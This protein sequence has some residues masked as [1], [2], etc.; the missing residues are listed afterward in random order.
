M[1]VAKISGGQLAYMTAI[2]GIGVILNQPTVGWSEDFA[3]QVD[4]GGDVY[5]AGGY[6]S[7]TLPTTF[8]AFEA[9]SPTGGAYLLKLDPSGTKLLFSTFIGS[10]GNQTLVNAME[11]DA[12]GNIYVAGTTSESTFPTTPGALQPGS[13]IGQ[14]L[15][16]GFISKFSPG[17]KLL[18]STLYGGGSKLDQ[19]NIASIAVDGSGVVHIAGQLQ[20][21]TPNQGFVARL[22]SSLTTLLFSKAL[23]DVPNSIQADSKGASYVAGMEMVTKIDASGAVAYQT[24]LPSGGFASLLL[25]DGSLAVAG[26]ATVRA[27]FPLKDTLEPCP[28][29]RGQSS[30]SPSF[31]PSAVFAMLDSTGQITL[32]TYLGGTGSEITSMVAGPGGSLYLAGWENGIDFPGGP[33]LAGGELQG[34]AFAFELNMSAIPRGMPSPGCVVTISGEQFAPIAP[35]MIATIFGNNLG[36]AT[37]AY[38]QL[39]STGAVPAQLAGISVTVGGAPAPILYAQD[40]QINFIIPQA[41]EGQSTSV[42]VES[43]A[44]QSCLSLP[45]QPMFPMI[46]HTPGVGYAILNQDGTL[47]TPANPPPRGSV[48][49]LFGTGMGAYDRTLPDGS[50]WGMPVAN[51]TAPVSASFVFPPAE[52]GACGM[53]W[54]PPCPPPS[55]IRGT[56]LFAG[57]APDEVVGVTQINVAI[58]EGAPMGSDVAL[59]LAFGQGSSAD[60]TVAIQ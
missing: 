52:L 24:E 30:F 58:P 53:M 43:T 40:G 4:S 35:G 26:S 32:S 20:T 47:N 41:V 55:A 17:G 12:Q 1:V 27:N 37:G 7:P 50:I 42:C 5:L 28:P 2:G 15:T 54:L 25:Q 31:P 48:I 22:D 60:V 23:S 44:G 29:D 21:A 10:N 49:S 19:T 45:V 51:L 13:S 57:G 16:A 11:F 18:A 46:F 38:F 34:S 14:A 3:M 8:A 56:V 59:G 36:P 33:I 9:L 6:A 39:D